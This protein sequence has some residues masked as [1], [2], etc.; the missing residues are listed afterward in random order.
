M[1][2]K[3]EPVYDNFFDELFLSSAN[4]PWLPWI[5]KKFTSTKSRT[6]ILG[7]SF[8]VW[9]PGDAKTIAKF[10]N[11]NLLREQHIH[12]ALDYKRKSKFV[13]NIERAV[14]GKRNP[15][16]L[17]KQNFWESVIYHNLVLRPMSSIKERP[18]FNDYKKG[19]EVFINIIKIIEISQCIVYGLENSKI[20]ALRIYLENNNFPHRLHTQKETI[21]KHKPRILSID[22][23][24]K[25]VKLLF[26]RHPSA[27]F[28]WKNWHA[29]IA[30]EIDV[31]DFQLTTNSSR[32]I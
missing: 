10:D 22:I 14:F 7:E 31:T 30:N 21:G 27:Y 23:G 25:T 15:Q 4:L 17:S 8:Y 5:G 20:K 12:H 11:Q 18:N 28:S 32:A 6:A 24:E 1:T 13:R 26:I 9:K 19:W 2:D 3:K 29:I 16:N